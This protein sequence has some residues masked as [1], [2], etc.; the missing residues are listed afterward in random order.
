MFRKT[1]M[2]AAIASLAT[3]AFAAVSAD[4]AKQLGTT[5]TAVGAEKAGNKE[6]TIPEYTGGLKDIPATFK[7]GSGIRPVAV[8][9]RKAAPRHRRQERRAACR[10]ADRGHQGA[11]QA[12][13]DSMR[14]DVYPTHR[15]V[16]LPQKVLANT[17]K[18]ATA[19]KSVNGGL[20]VEGMLP[21]VPFPI[22][23]SGYEAMWNHLVRYTGR[24]LQRQVRELERGFGGRGLAV[25][26]GQHDQRVSAVR[27]EA[28]RHRRPRRTTRTSS[29]S[30]T[31]R[32]RRAAPVRR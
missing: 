6:G 25:D 7:K 13:S 20:G 5:L 18:N 29:S 30:S 11:A 28:G 22:P 32:A 10:Q 23:K 31:T 3:S 17:A 12:L 16:A 15:V 26:V 4:E 8:R 27:P 24:C 1:S 9:E 14:L 19:T 21:G 2:A